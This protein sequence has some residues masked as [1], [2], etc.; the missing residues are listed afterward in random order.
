MRDDS[1]YICIAHDNVLSRARAVPFWIAGVA[2]VVFLVGSIFCAAGLRLIHRRN[3]DF[4]SRSL[5]YVAANGVHC[6]YS[7]WIG[8]LRLEIIR[9]AD[10]LLGFKRGR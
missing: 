8:G 3:P 5:F 1:L 4:I 10:Y 9:P 7:D 6:E 2:R